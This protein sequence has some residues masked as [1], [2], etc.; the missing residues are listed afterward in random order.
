MSSILNEL[1]VDP[2][3][4]SW[5]DLALC[6]GMDVNLFYEKYEADQSIA[7]SIDQACLTCPVISICYDAGVKNNEYGVW[8]GVYLNS[9]SIDKARNIHKTDEIWNRLRGKNVY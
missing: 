8:G 1:G 9:G 7:N 2:D 5:E 4:F 6:Q 3:D